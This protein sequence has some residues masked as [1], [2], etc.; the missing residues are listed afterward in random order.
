M[1]LR[2]ALDQIADIRGQ[3]ARAM[4]FR[5]YRA[6]TTAFSGLLGIGASLWQAYYIPMSGFSVI[7]YLWL[8]LSV[9]MISIA[10]IG[11]ELF[12]RAWRTDSKM[13]R[14]QTLQ[15]VQQF[16]PCLLAGLLVSVAIVY[17]VWS[18]C[19]ML[20]GLWSV[21][22]G[23]GIFASLRSLPPAAVWVALYYVGG[24]AIA[25]SLRDQAGF[26]PATMAILFGIGQLL[27]ALVLYVSERRYD[28]K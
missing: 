5:G 17:H 12:I 19:W 16:L 7:A 4:A 27:A 26:H 28:A 20:P 2:D 18:A 15:A 14:E 24:G 23:L 11:T 22:F 6:L 8:W 9:A 10:L 25:I 3:M 21:I 1:D 13:Q